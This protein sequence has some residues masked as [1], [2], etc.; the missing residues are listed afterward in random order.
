MYLDA[1]VLIAL[2]A[3]EPTSGAVRRFLRAH[4]EDRLISDFAAAEVASAISRLLRMRL[5]TEVEG[6][7]RLADFDAWRAAATSAA[8]VHAADARLAYI[9]V[10]RFDLGLRAPD[11]LH[12]AIARR[13]DA[14][15]VTLDRR[16]AIAANQLGVAVEA[17][18]AS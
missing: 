18:R 17:L 5:L 9:Y 14:T 13:L 16:L 11:A 2:L 4:R 12:L 6:S 3:E 10:R 8:D 1:S 7:T 15:L